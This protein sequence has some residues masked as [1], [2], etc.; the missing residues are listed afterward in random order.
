MSKTLLWVTLR[1]KLFTLSSALISLL[2]ND[3]LTNS[4]YVSLG[5]L[6]SA[7]TSPKLRNSV[8]SLLDLPVIH[9]IITEFQKKKLF[10][11]I[12]YDGIEPAA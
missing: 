11:I 1:L 7:N 9:D 10:V 4:L 12:I 8:S 5:L 6:R 2:K 3:D